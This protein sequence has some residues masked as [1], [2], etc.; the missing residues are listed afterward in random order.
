LSTI[1]LSG[2]GKRLR[3]TVRNIY[4]DTFYPQKYG[5]VTEK[6]LSPA[7]EKNLRMYQWENLKWEWCNSKF[8]SIRKESNTY[9]SVQVLFYAVDVLPSR[10]PGSYMCKKSANRVKPKFREIRHL[11]SMQTLHVSSFFNPG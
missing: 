8:V 10:K 4:M 5:L 11:T 1:E 2:A 6:N 7:N 9:C 3:N